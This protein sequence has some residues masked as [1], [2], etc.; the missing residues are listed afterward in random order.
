MET[1]GI[2]AHILCNYL[3]AAA[4]CW[5]EHITKRPC[6]ST[7]WDF[8]HLLKNL[9]HSRL[10]HVLTSDLR[11]SGQEPDLLLECSGPLVSWACRRAKR[12]S[13]TC[14]EGLVMM[15]L[16]PRCSVVQ[17][18]Q[19]DHHLHHFTHLIPLS[20]T[21][22]SQGKPGRAATAKLPGN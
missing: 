9:C 2:W 7:F 5:A 10:N 13:C 16:P 6:T 18:K 17:K 15:Q 22:S 12:L 1:T 11:G 4:C 14:A 20:H 3:R 21:D 19:R 8:I